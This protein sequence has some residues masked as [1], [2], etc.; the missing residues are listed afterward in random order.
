MIF[1]T[2]YV[3]VIISM[4]IYIYESTLDCKWANCLEIMIKSLN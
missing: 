2:F 3:N 4:E 1:G